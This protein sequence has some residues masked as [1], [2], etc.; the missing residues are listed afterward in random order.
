MKKLKIVVYIIITIILG[1]G[2]T[3][4]A[5]RETI[6]NSIINKIVQSEKKKHDLNIK[7]EEAKFVGLTTVSFKDI[8]IVPQD[9]D[10]LL[11]VENF[12]VSVSIFPLFLGH[13][14]IDELKTNNAVLNIIH[15]NGQR[16]FDFLLKR[17]AKVLSLEWKR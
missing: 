11:R 15:K 9:R 5:M 6:L 3:A 16:N 4:F 1:V 10:T 12:R 17:W 7:I 13:I 2:I 8:S 14:K